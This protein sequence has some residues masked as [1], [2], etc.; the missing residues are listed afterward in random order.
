MKLHD[1]LLAQAQPLCGENERS[2]TVSPGQQSAGSGANS[3]ATQRR[4]RLTGPSLWVDHLRHALPDLASARR[5][6]ALAQK[7][8][9]A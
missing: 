9:Q 3:T 5:L 2:S 7:L 4:M 1:A 6:L 8:G